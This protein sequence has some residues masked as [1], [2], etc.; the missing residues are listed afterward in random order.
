MKLLSRDDLNRALLARQMLLARE[1]VPP[2]K[3]IEPFVPLPAKAKA[4]L[5]REGERLIS[6]AEPEAE[7]FKV[8]FRK[9]SQLRISPHRHREHRE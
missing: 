6:F 9:N 2:L 1:S 5:K 4:E 7:S 3:V 8:E